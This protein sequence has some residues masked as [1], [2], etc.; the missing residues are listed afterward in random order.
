MRWPAWTSLLWETPVACPLCVPLASGQTFQPAFL[1]C[2]HL[3]CY[4][5]RCWEEVRVVNVLCSERK[6][7]LM[8]R[9]TPTTRYL[10]S[11]QK[12]S[13]VPFWWPPLKVAITCCVPWG[14]ELSSILGWTL[15]QVRY[16]RWLQI[17]CFLRTKLS[18]RRWVIRSF[19]VKKNKHNLRRPV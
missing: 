6:G 3:T 10:L 17:F 18:F 14:M 19:A 5:R 16:K 7:W 8:L 12:L 11:L 4:T 9:V 15:R 1:N 2:L 13:H